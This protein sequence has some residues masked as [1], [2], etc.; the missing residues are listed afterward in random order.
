M[1]VCT[2][3]T[4]GERAG[5]DERFEVALREVMSH[6]EA[7]ARLRATEADAQAALSEAMR[8]GDS[9][10]R[11]L[12]GAGARQ[13]GARSRELDHATEMLEAISGRLEVALA[14]ARS[15]ERVTRLRRAI[16]QGNHRDAAELGEA[17]FAGLSSPREAPE[18]VYAPFP[19]RQRSRRQGE[20]LLDPEEA[21]LALAKQARDGI[22]APT[23]P[24]DEIPGAMTLTASQDA[25]GTDYCLRATTKELLVPVLSNEA[26]GELWLFASKLPGPL[27]PCAAAD[28]SD[29]WWAAAPISYSE[30]LGRVQRGL[31]ERGID[32][33]VETDQG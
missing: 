17:I 3:V 32:L 1:V 16:E 7:A 11:S 20:T 5:S 21:T 18:Y 30:Y 27:T 6:Q 26:T 9:L 33:V 29:E 24:K 10:R 15:D 31:R 22:D 19:V 2:F 23:T 14:A 28:S 4:A 25:S 12:R 13:A 8:L